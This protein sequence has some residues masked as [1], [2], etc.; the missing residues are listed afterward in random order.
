MNGSVRKNQGLGQPL[1]THAEPTLVP[2]L[3][4][5][6]ISDLARGGEAAL[7]S[8]GTRRRFVVAG[9]AARPRINPVFSVDNLSQGLNLSRLHPRKPWHSHH[10]KDSADP[11][12]QRI[13][14][15]DA[16]YAEADI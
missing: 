3:L 10:L 6:S 15:Q 2:V 5:S 16:K 13:R 4:Y 11:G 14:C 7:E 8:V 1:T 12:K 9:G